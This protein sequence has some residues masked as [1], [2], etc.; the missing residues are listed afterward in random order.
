MDTLQF[1]QA[2]FPKATDG[3]RE[4]KH[5]KPPGRRAR[6]KH[7]FFFYNPKNGISSMQSLFVE[8]IS[9]ARESAVFAVLDMVV[10][11]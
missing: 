8:N 2:Q 1:P 7:F 11:I 6:I 10:Y 4:G 5:S 9:L 3:W